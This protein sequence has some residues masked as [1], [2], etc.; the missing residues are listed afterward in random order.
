[1]RCPIQRIIANCTSMAP[2]R[3]RLSIVLDAP[4][5]PRKGLARKHSE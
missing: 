2:T 4:S 5:L 1:M 3:Q